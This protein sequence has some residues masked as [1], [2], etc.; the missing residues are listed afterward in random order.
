[1][2]LKASEVAK[3]AIKSR[4]VLVY[5]IFEAL[6]RSLG[7]IVGGSGKS[8]EGGFVCEGCRV[9]TI[10]NFMGRVL[11]HQ[12]EKDP[13]LANQDCYSTSRRI[14]KISTSRIAKISKSRIAKISKH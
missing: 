5:L 13:G 1:M 12:Q 6:L 8:S 3:L 10:G 7:V 4:K 9:G 2:C 14:A 11:F